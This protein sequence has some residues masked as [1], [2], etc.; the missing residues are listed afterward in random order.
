MSVRAELT[1]MSKMKMT[2]AIN[3][4]ER[5]R[6]W[7]MTIITAVCVMILGCYWLWEMSTRREEELPLLVMIIASKVEGNISSRINNLDSSLPRY[8]TLQNLKALS[9]REPTGNNDLSKSRHLHL[10]RDSKSE[11]QFGWL[12]IKC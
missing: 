6:T 1:K 9:W 12:P 7:H 2:A 3:K 5:V 8:A 10:C 4:Q 11:A